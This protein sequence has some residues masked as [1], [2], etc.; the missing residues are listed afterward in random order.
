MKEAIL[1]AL[2]NH[3][4]EISVDDCYLDG[5]YKVL[6]QDKLR[7]KILENLQCGSDQEKI[8]QA[9][10]IT[11]AV[12]SD[13]GCIVLYSWGVKIEKESCTD[14]PAFRWVIHRNG[15]HPCRL[16]FEIEEKDGI[17]KPVA[18]CLRPTTVGMGYQIAKQ[19]G[20]PEPIIG[21]LEKW[22]SDQ[23][24]AEKKEYEC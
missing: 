12:I 5:E 11:E 13:L 18:P 19:L 3:G 2:K 9:F 20:R 14:C 6:L 23:Y 7:Q 8:I 1:D 21:R 10:E 15:T 22:Q 4:I 24:E 16:G 17:G